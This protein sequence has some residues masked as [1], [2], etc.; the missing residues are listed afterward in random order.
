MKN[1]FFILFVSVLTLNIFSCQ[2]DDNF[3]E[4]IEN[5]IAHK[6]SISIESQLANGREVEINVDSLFAVHG[7]LESRN[8]KTQIYHASVYKN[9]TEWNG[10]NIT[11]AEL[12][13][14]NFHMEVRNG[15]GVASPYVYGQVN[16]SNWRQVKGSSSGTT[17]VITMTIN[18]L[19][20][21][22][23]HGFIG[24]Y[25]STSGTATITIFRE[26]KSGSGSGSSGSTTLSITPSNVSPASGNV[27]T[28]NF[29]F[30]VQTNPKPVSTMTATVEFKAPDNKTYTFVMDRLTQGFSHRRTL[31]QGGTYQYRYVVKYNGQTQTSSWMSI[32]VTG[33]SGS[34]SGSFPTL[35][36]IGGSS[37]TNYFT[38][39]KWD[40][41]VNGPG[42]YKG[43]YV[44]N[45]YDN[46]NSYNYWTIKG[47]NFGSQNSTSKIYTN[48]A[49]ISLQVISWSNTEIKVRPIANYS[50]TF[51][52]GVNIKVK[53]SNG[54]EGAISINVMGMLQNGRGFG[55]CT[56]EVA[57][58]RLLAGKSIPATAYQS[59]GS[60][61]KNYTP[62][63]Y[64]VINW[65]GHT[66]IIVSEPVLN[67][68]NGVKTWTFNLRERNHDLSENAVTTA[69][70]FKRTNASVSGGIK[71]AASGLGSASNY[72]R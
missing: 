27:N 25:Y 7:D 64:D 28:T 2:K 48:N 57:Y 31:S 13:S 17:K 44:I 60:I 32:S 24:A 1:V 37:I 63:I 61:D 47:N 66:S 21:H 59:S 39:G 36:T 65:N 30:A 22:E 50:F 71:S 4:I 68:A 19:Q 45:T 46:S 62:K 51:A 6:D 18:D 3:A 35:N 14:Y 70:S 20:S 67:D 23:T 54:N 72:Y 10:M 56:W 53:N 15:S 8:G 43:Y 40:G 11:R 12:Q 49:S 41:N 38:D 52:T 9:K 69:K 58:Q 26:T 16:G 33:G 29:N 5:D 55:Q 42:K 34:G